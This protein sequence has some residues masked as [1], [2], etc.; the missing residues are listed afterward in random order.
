MY[1]HTVTYRPI[2]RQR[3][4]YVHTTIE[5]VLQEVFSICSAP[6]SLRGNGSLNIP[7]EANQ[8][9]KS[10]SIPRQRCGKQA[11]SI[12]QDVFSMGPP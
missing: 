3:P 5:K 6:W 10:T 12:M 1:I 11:L 7:A 8:L 9:K 2:S 4:K